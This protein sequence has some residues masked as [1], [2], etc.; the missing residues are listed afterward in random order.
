VHPK[1]VLK[2]SFDT[3]RRA[4]IQLKMH[5]QSAIPPVLPAVFV[6]QPP[7]VTCSGIVQ[8]VLLELAFGNAAAAVKIDLKTANPV[9]MSDSRENS[10]LP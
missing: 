8:C 1:R 4:S 3:S 10:S 2:L 6:P 5:A 7:Y 9:A